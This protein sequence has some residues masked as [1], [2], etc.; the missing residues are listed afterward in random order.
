MSEEGTAFN[1]L[2]CWAVQI[3]RENGVWLPETVIQAAGQFDA[4]NSAKV[5]GYR[6]SFLPIEFERHIGHLYHFCP[7]L[8]LSIYGLY[9]FVDARYFSLEKIV[10]LNVRQSARTGFFELF[11]WCGCR[12][13]WTL[14]ARTAA[15][16]SINTTRWAGQSFSSYGDWL[17]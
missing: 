15:E 4:E 12:R 8:F 13:L 6:E 10:V 17:S 11:L 3:S 5:D 2:C 7:I 1:Q 9:I 14:S 16:G